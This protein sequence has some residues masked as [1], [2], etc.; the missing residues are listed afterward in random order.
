MNRA[1]HVY[2]RLLKLYPKRYRDQYEALL[3]QSF[4]DLYREVEGR[5]SLSLAG[6]WLWIGADTIKGATGEWYR[7]VVDTPPSKLTAFALL[8]FL[9]VM[10]VNLL[11]HATAALFGQ[12]DALF[13]ELRRPLDSIS[14][15]YPIGYAAVYLAI[16]RVLPRLARWG[17]LAM[18]ALTFLMMIPGFALFPIPL[19]VELIRPVTVTLPQ[20]V[21]TA[22]SLSAL[23]ATI[24]FGFAGLSL[25]SLD[26]VSIGRMLLGMIA[27]F[28]WAVP[29]LSTAIHL[30]DFVIHSVPLLTSLAWFILAYGALLQRSEIKA[31][32]E[33]GS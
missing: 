27:V 31:V 7:G 14:W 17:L 29:Y 22:L 18:L 8:L 26:A 23:L 12:G 28:G 33:G 5:D 19:P 20:W 1:L 9:L 32:L 24:L 6:F 30:S 13:N 4:G 21:W 2:A 15:L 25:R 11:N 16:A 10:G 3:I